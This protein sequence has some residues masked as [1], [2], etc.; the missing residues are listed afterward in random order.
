MRVLWVDVVGGDIPQT[1]CQNHGP[2][3]V[4]GR[5]VFTNNRLGSHTR[6]LV[7][8]EADNR[9]DK[10]GNI[11]SGRD[12]QILIQARLTRNPSMTRRMLIFRRVMEMPGVARRA[13]TNRELAEP[14]TAHP[15][16]N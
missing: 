11:R 6:Y 5:N 1:A 13:R 14:A 4:R 3:R 12:S 9:A 16:R 2:C 7:L 15:P 10:K 8:G